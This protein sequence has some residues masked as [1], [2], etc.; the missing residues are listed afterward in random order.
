MVVLLRAGRLVNWFVRPVIGKVSCFARRLDVRGLRP[1]S[2]SDVQAPLVVQ[3]GEVVPEVA[4][5]GGDGCGPAQPAVGTVV[6]VEVHEAVVG[7][8]SLVSV[9]QSRIWAHS[10]RRMRWKRSTFP[11]V[12]GR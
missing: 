3:A 8:G 7:E 1:P 10:S 2:A 9:R 12:W 4:V 6:I 11:L 5:E